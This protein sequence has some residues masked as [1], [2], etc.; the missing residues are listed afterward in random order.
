MQPIYIYTIKLHISSN[1]SEVS[2]KIKLLCITFGI[3]TGN[4]VRDIWVRNTVYYYFYIF[5]YLFNNIE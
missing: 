4:F 5:L 1:F 3:C 2:C